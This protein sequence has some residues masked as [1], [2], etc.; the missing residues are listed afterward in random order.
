MDHFFSDDDFLTP[1][2]QFYL[3][4]NASIGETVE[5][6]GPQIEPSRNETRTTSIKTLNVLA[7]VEPGLVA[8]VLS[9]WIDSRPNLPR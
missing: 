8:S 5:Y 2:D 4:D 1:T 7:R 3:D 9:D 6:R